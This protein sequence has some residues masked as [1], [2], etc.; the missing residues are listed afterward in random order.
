MGDFNM[1]LSGKNRTEL[2]DLENRELFDRVIAV[3]SKM[4]MI[5]ANTRQLNDMTIVING[6]LSQIDGSFSSFVKTM[7][8]FMDEVRDYMKDNR[9]FQDS[10]K[11]HDGLV[12]DHEKC[13]E[14]LVSKQEKYD[15]RFNEIDGMKKLINVVLVIASIFGIGFITENVSCL[16][17]KPQ[18]NNQYHVTGQPEPTPPMSSFV[19]PSNAS[20]SSPTK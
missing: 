15:K 19:G 7:D 12:H 16:K 18:E 17:K 14:A 11:R 9:E 2:N 4:G 1:D 20:A 6:K 10:A 3:E 13:M 5:D 8:S